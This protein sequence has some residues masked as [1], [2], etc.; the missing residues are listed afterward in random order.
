[1]KKL[2][3]VVVVVV[4]VAGLAGAV[5]AQVAQAPTQ[6]AA[7]EA[8]AQAPAG[9]AAGG[10]HAMGALGRRGYLKVSPE[11][12]QLWDQLGTLQ[13][14]L[15]QE[16]WDLFVLLN[17]EPKDREAIK[18]QAEKVRGLTQ[19]VRQTMQSLRQYFVAL[20]AAAGTRHPANG[21]GNNAGGQPPTAQTTTPNNAG[22]QT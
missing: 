17:A 11:S 7:P 22:P 10:Q 16:Q 20:P 18:A 3:Y 8:G 21:Q 12:Q 13:T 4:L 1:M 5:W 14:Q 9:Q 6:Q 2:W 19:Q 15:H